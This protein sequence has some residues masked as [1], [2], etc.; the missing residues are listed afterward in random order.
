M[1]Y[2]TEIYHQE[3]PHR[4]KA[5]YMYLKDRSNKEGQCYPSIR[6]IAGE[7]QLSRRTVERGI[8]DLVRAGFVTKEQRWRE[9]GGRSS[10][11]FTLK[12]NGI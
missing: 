3:L 5:V 6:T 7:L 11:L 2:F 1:G 9:N 8:D 10:L 4:A 12:G